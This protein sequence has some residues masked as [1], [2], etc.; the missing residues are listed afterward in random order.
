MARKYEK[1]LSLMKDKGG[2]IEVADADL[3]ATL[4]RLIY[5]TPGYM[6]CIRRYAKLEV[7]SIRDGRKVVAYELAALIPAAVETPDVASDVTPDPDS[8]VVATDGAENV[9]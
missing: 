8:L 2:R 7:R 5:K 3:Q 6:S 4:G 1:V 9:A